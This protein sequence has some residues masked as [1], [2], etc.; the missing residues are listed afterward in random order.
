MDSTHKTNKHS[1]KLYTLMGR[2]SFG[3]W[4]PGGH[5]FISN[6]EQHI[7][8]SGLQIIKYWAKTWQPRYF[9]ID[10]SAIEE[11][12]INNTFHG[13]IAGEQIV[14]ILYCTWHIRQTLQRRL[15]SFGKSYALML[16]AMYKHTRPGCD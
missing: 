7:I 4:L 2:N 16:Q 9:L 6:E 8:A 11:K 1:W 14:D 10:Q 13:L 12:A 15:G 5:F 3:S